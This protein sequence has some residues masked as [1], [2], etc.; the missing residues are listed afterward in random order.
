[1]VC[2]ALCTDAV[3]SSAFASICSVSIPGPPSVSHRHPYQIIAAGTMSWTTDRKLRLNS[4][5]GHT[6]L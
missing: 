3:N 2:L 4:R 6:M 1:M 5:V